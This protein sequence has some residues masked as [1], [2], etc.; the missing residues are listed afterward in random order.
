[1][2]QRKMFIFFGNYLQM[3]YSFKIFETKKFNERA[4]GEW[5]HNVLVKT[6]LMLD[7]P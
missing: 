5:Y 7:M 4:K 6:V 3:F 2:A 1:M